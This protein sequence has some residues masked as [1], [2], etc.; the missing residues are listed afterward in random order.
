MII[1]IHTHI[2]KFGNSRKKTPEELLSSMKEA[3]ID[4]SFVIANSDSE[5][6][7]TST[8]EAVAIRE[9]FPQLKIIGAVNYETFGQNQLQELKE[10]LRTKKIVGVK[11][12]TGYEHFYPNDQKLH[13]LY[14]FC[15][16]GGIPV[17]FHTGLLLVGSQGL[18]KYS[19]PLH[20]DELANQ[21]PKLKIVIAHFGN[22]WLADCGAVLSKN[23]N[24]YA[25]LS[26]FFTEYQPISIKE[27]KEFAECVEYLASF[28]G[29]FRKLVFGTDWPLY[30]QKEY[31]QAV[32]GLKMNKE[33]RDLVM[34]KNAKDIFNL[35]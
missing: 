9:R 27:K 14:R 18:L 29:G 15:S 6:E 31:L 32:Q 19:H 34:W 10:L 26:G 25:D 8:K 11:L 24:V 4:I 22:P 13:E 1:D 2:A 7:G 12:Y 3:K 23:A 20:I 5:I 28:L 16:D 33:E 30:S 35:E 17:M 21:F